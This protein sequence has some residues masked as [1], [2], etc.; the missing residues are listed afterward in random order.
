MRKKFYQIVIQS[1]DDK[2]DFRAFCHCE[3]SDG[4]KWELRAHGSSA[5][6]AAADAWTAYVGDD[7]AL[8]GYIVK[9]FK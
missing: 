5:A 8:D 7:W 2:E 9:D 6:E 1:P 4:N 3:D